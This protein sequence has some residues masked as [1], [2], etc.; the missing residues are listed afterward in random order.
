M[1]SMVSVVVILILMFIF[2]AL[3]SLI[4]VTTVLVVNPNMFDVSVS[5][6]SILYLVTRCFTQRPLYGLHAVFTHADVKQRN[7][8]TEYDTVKLGE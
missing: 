2:V 8:H 3:H 7:P 1:A 6:L 5:P 4:H